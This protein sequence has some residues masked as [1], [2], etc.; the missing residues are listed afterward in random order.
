[1][2][3]IELESKGIF[4]PKC[5]SRMN[6][7][8]RKSMNQYRCIEDPEHYATDEKIKTHRKVVLE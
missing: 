1:M 8:G 7:F 2:D 3:K 5:G 4:C 6:P